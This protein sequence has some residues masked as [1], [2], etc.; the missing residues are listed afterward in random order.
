MKWRRC[1]YD[2]WELIDDDDSNGF[3]S[4]YDT[5]HRISH[6]EFVWCRSGRLHHHDDL[7]VRVKK[8]RTAC[9][10]CLGYCGIIQSIL[11]LFLVARPCNAFMGTHQA[12]L[13]LLAWNDDTPDE[14]KNDIDFKWEEKV[15]QVHHHKAVEQLQMWL[16]LA[17]LWWEPA[18]PLWLTHSS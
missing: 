7:I 6:V 13:L 2:E 18:L 3:T 10:Q 14:G 15:R 4:C 12:H 16:L 1:S 17:V 11:F 9:L 8:S 5:R